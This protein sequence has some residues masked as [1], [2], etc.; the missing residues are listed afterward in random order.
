MRNN[1]SNGKVFWRHFK[2]L[3]S[4]QN[5]KVTCEQAFAHFSKS[6]HSPCSNFPIINYDC[7]GPLDFPIELIELNG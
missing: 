4:R 2:S 1:A 7:I 6:F 5:V 3:K